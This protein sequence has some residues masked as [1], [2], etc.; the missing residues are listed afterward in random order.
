MRRTNSASCS[1]KIPDF[2]QGVFASDRAYLLYSRD[3]LRTL[4]NRTVNAAMTSSD[5]ERTAAVDT[6]SSL[7]FFIGKSH[8][9]ALDNPWHGEDA[10]RRIGGPRYS[11]LLASPLVSG[12]WR[13]T[14]S[15]RLLSRPVVRRRPGGGAR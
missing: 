2:T 6:S 10:H 15:K 8:S 7:Q 14:S 13:R 11:S 3:V 5:P 1:A 4:K 12:R 9:R